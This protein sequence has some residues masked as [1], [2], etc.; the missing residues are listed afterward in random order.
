MS[1]TRGE[2]EE[3]DR[4]QLPTSRVHL[5]DDNLGPTII[6][7]RG[8]EETS[9]VL[10]SYPYPTALLSARV[11]ARRLRKTANRPRAGLWRRY[12]RLNAHRCD[13][14]VVIRMKG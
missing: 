2:E 14:I 1:Q 11:A 3:V 9:S 10:A 4:A 6:R 5:T 7:P 8:G 12:G 13:K